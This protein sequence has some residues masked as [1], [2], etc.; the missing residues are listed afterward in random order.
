MV[1]D[2]EMGNAEPD[3]EAQSLKEMHGLTDAEV[4]VAM[5]IR[6][7]CR[8]K[9]I[10]EQLKVPVHTVRS[11]S[12]RTFHKL[13]VSSQANLVRKILGFQINRKLPLSNFPEE[14]ARHVGDR[15]AARGILEQLAE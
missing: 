15:S 14:L 7:G 13:C 12:K 3:N 1:N 6:G 10:A 9:D 8:V 2:P 11:H 5:S 4:R